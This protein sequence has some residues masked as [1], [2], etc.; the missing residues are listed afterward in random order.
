MAA[1]PKTARP[2]YTLHIR[3]NCKTYFHVSRKVRKVRKVAMKPKLRVLCELSVRYILKLYNYL[4]LR[5]RA[6]TIY[7]A[8]A[9]LNTDAL[10]N[11]ATAWP[12]EV[13][14]PADAA[15]AKSAG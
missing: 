10:P 5:R 8:K 9:N 14:R 15:S 7:A 3:A 4:T 1:A 11:Q 2:S 6:N 12:R 13:T